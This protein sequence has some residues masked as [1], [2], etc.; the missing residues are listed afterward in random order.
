VT[1][2]ALSRPSIINQRIL[3][4]GQRIYCMTCVVFLSLSLS[5][6]LSFSTHE[7]EI[8]APSGRCVPRDLLDLID[9]TVRLDASRLSQQ[10]RRRTRLKLKII[11]LSISQLNC[12]II[13]PKKKA[14]NKQSHGGNVT[15]CVSCRVQVAFFFEYNAK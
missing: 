7:T 14:L 3:V 1:F 10:V 6:F 13:S 2:V 11:T 12:L 5:L 8:N 15:M 4:S 9:L